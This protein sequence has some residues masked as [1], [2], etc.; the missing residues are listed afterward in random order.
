MNVQLNLILARQRAAELQRAGERARLAREVRMRGRK[1][2]HRNLITRLRARPARVLGSLIVAVMLAVLALSAPAATA[3]PLGQV[4][5]FSTGLPAGTYPEWIA[6]GPDGNLWFTDEGT[7]RAIGRITRSGQITE[8]STGLNP[9]AYPVGITV[10]PDGDMW[11]ADDGATPA[12]GR[13]A[14]SGQITEFSAGL[15]RR[16]RTRSGSRP[17]RTGTSGSPTRGRT[18]AIGRI[19]PVGADH[20]VLHQPKPGHVPGRDH[21]GAGRRPL[22]RRRG[23]RDWADRFGRPARAGRPGERLRRKGGG[24][25]RGL[26]NAV[27]VLDGVRPIPA[28]VPLRRL[29]MVAR[30]DAGR[31]SDGADLRPDGRRRRPPTRLPADRH[32]PAPV[33]G[34]RDRNQPRDHRPACPAPTPDAGALGAGHRAPD[35]HACGAPGRGAVSAVEALHA[36][37]HAAGHDRDQRWRGR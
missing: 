8:F 17:G 15:N 30:R 35:V 37:A 20:R 9:R 3:D 25:C 31:G 34:H 26:P 5:E 7:T 6:A 4:S 16:Q 33:F 36:P 24:K 29:R 10:G 1:L 27:V 19:T 2:P 13:I 21:G 12:I 23:G 28:A 22:V 14:P 18:N 32:L 11:F